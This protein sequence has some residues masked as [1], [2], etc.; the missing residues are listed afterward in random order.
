MLAQYRIDRV[1]TLLAEGK[2]SPRKIEQQTGVS[3]GSIAKIAVGK[4][5]APPPAGAYRPVGGFD[6]PLPPPQRCRECGRL[7]YP[8]CR[9]CRA[10]LMPPLPQLQ[11][12][13]P[14]PRAKIVVGLALRIR[15]FNR[16][17]EVRKQRRQ[18]EAAARSQ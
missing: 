4:R 16:Y 9:A 3:R 1:R 10:S 13:K 15:H 12:L 11:R 18:M 7:V 6:E 5:P 14:G 8:P 17:L 2:L